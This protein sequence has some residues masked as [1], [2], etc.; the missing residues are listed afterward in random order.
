MDTGADMDGDTGADTDGDTDGDTGADMGADM[1][2]DTHMLPQAPS[3]MDELGPVL[4]A[5][6]TTP[7]VAVEV[8]AGSETAE[9]LTSSAT[10]SLSPAQRSYFWFQLGAWHA[11]RGQ[12]NHRFVVALCLCLCLRLC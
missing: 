9:D 4:T 5:I 12:V 10:S 7:S 3:G 6:L 11:G 2:G 8:G 1:D